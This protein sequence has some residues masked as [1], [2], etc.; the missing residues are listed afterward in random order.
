MTTHKPR[1]APRLSG[2]NEVRTASGCFQ[3]KGDS[4]AF[5]VFASKGSLFRLGAPVFEIDGRETAGAIKDITNVS[6]RTLNNGVIE[7]VFSGT[8]KRAPHLSLDIVLRHSPLTPVVR[9]RYI[10]KSSRPIKLTKSSGK[11]ALI[12]TAMSLRDFGIVKAVRM[13]EFFQQPHSYLLTE[14]EYATKDFVGISEQGPILCGISDKLSVLLAYEHGSPH[15]QSFV[16]FK[17]R[18]GKAVDLAA[19]KG[20]YLRNARLDK[21]TS[22]ET[23]WMEFAAVNAGE[24]ELASAYRTFVLKY[25]AEDNGS[26]SPHI[27]YN[28]WGVQERNKWREG[29][30]YMSSM[31][32]GAI[33]KEID[34]AKKIGVDVFVIDWGWQELIGDWKVNLERFPD[35]LRKIKAKLD[36]CGMKLGLWCVPIL[37]SL[38][39]HLIRENPGLEK[40]RDGQIEES[41]S[42]PDKDDCKWMCYMSRYR[43]LFV[44]RLKELID[45]IGVSYFKLD[46]FDIVPCGGDNHF[47]GGKDVTE[48]ERLDNWSFQMPILFARS[49]QELARKLPGVIVDYDVTEPRRAMGLSVLSGGKYFLLNNGPYLRNLNLP[50]KPGVYNNV[51]VY[52]GPAR[53][54]LMREALVYDKWI[55]SV[56]FLTGYLPDKPASSQIINIASLIL[57]Q[58]GIWGDLASLDKEDIGMFSKWLGIYK[59]VKNDITEASPVRTGEIG[60]CPEIHEK[61]NTNGRGVVVIF[62]ESKGIYEYVTSA[63]PAAGVKCSDGAR[64]SKLKDGRAKITAQFSEPSAKMIFFGIKGGLAMRRN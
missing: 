20:N 8:L 55:P 39:S 57:G 16:E 38:K 59:M 7:S 45:E 25:L 49:S 21:G 35:G 42:L 18:A 15:P 51:F 4:D 50:E 13:S 58:N 52:P 48:Q 11:D 28:T 36:S 31:N 30:D 61:I 44:N 14:K 60:G 37:A 22:H 53:P 9:F 54:R 2:T 17:L 40:E 29:K 6:S 26:R 56:L 19:V 62:A 12:Y 43:E 47:H 32:L 34:V 33:L 23:L 63:K 5:V 46:F 10:L 64:V 27:F 1:H 24:K 41:F 3:V